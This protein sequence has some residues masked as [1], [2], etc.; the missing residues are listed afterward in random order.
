M[1]DIK[2]TVGIENNYLE[3][4]EVL[5]KRMETMVGG[6]EYNKVLAEHKRL[7]QDYINKRQ[8]EEEKKVPVFSSKQLSGE[9]LKRDLTKVEHVKLSLDYRDAVIR[10]SGKDPWVGAGITEQDAA[11]VEGHFKALLEEYG[12]NPNEF[13][14]RFDQSLIDDP[15]MMM[16]IK[17]RKNKRK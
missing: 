5:K 9:L 7:T 11:Q 14:Y 15:E 13:T 12:D 10:E 6:D 8:P 2:E 1:E 16:A 3:E 17:A 4:I